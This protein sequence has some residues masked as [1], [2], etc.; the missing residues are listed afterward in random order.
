MGQ[1]Y[2][3]PKLTAIC[4]TVRKIDQIYARTEASTCPRPPPGT[5]YTGLSS[6][7]DLQVDF[8]EIKPC[9]AS[10]YLLVLVCTSSGW[11]EAFTTKTKK[12]SN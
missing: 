8:A 1:Y 4:V 5:Q 2:Y 12:A 10:K 9:Q 7:E 11:P 6:F 3:I